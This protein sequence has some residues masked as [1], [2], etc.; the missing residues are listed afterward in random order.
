MKRA[1]SHTVR[2]VQ[3][4]TAGAPFGPRDDVEVSVHVDVTENRAVDRRAILLPYCRQGRDGP[5]GV[6]LIP[7]ENIPVAHARRNE[8][9]FARPLQHAAAPVPWRTMPALAH[10]TG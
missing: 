2:T 5:V 7:L 3:E 8:P 1:V 9:D 6:V 10:S 4:G